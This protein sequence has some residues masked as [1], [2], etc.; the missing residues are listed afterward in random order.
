MALWPMLQTTTRHTTG[1]YCEFYCGKHLIIMCVPYVPCILPEL[2]RATAVACCCLSSPPVCAAHCLP[3]AVLQPC[4]A[5]MPVAA[6][7]PAARHTV[8]HQVV[9]VSLSPWHRWWLLLAPIQET[10]S[11]SAHTVRLAMIVVT[12][13][14]RVIV[15]TIQYNLVFIERVYSSNI[16]II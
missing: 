12:V 1:A 3:P 13:E 15:L 2:S 5:W 7:A 9:P 6:A 10:V 16:Y 8:L 14:C 11:D 4:M